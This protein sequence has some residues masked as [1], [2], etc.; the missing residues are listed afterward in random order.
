MTLRRRL[1]MLVV[2]LSA[3]GLV[4]STVVGTALLRRFVLHRVDRQLVSGF[5]NRGGGPGG[6]D[7]GVGGGGGR[8]P[9][10]GPNPNAPTDPDNVCRLGRGFQFSPQ[11]TLTELYRL[12]GSSLCPSQSVNDPG[13]GPVIERSD[14]LHPAGRAFTVSGH[15]SGHDYRVVVNALG[16]DAVVVRAIDLGEANATWRDQAL[17]GG[18]ISLATLV[19]IGGL[20][21]WLVHRGLR[22]LE[23]ISDTADAIAAG[24]RSQRAAVTDPAGEVGRLGLAFNTML[25][26]IDAAFVEQQHSEDKLRQFVADASHE[27]R[28]PLTSIRGYAEL[29]LAGGAATPAKLE[30]SMRN[31]KREAERMTGLVEDLLMLARMDREPQLQL[32]E[33]HLAR[34]VD[35]AVADLR[36]RDANRQVST[37][38]TA[39]V[40]V[41]GDE[42]RLRQVLA[43][44]ISNACTHTPA[45]TP[46]E[47]ALAEVGGRAEIRVIDH[48]HGVPAEMREHIFERFA[49]LDPS[50]TRASGGAGLGLAIVSAIVAAHRGSVRVEPTSGGGATFVVSLP[51]ASASA[52]AAERELAEAPVLPSV[53]GVHALSSARPGRNG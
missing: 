50:R 47:L 5:G 27:L 30:T 21:L 8:G 22:P 17:A 29:Q 25:E 34:L 11:G 15:S 38:A 43:N 41:A 33:V 13:G 51:L 6:P 52:P 12:D 26:S 7:G 10:L 49:R 53:A 4:V 14:L 18:L 9:G 48:G 42:G 1:V 19:A 23:E 45:A 40:R 24:D 37:V 16:N 39:R 32:S 46:I 31:I 2:G 28:T 35:D 3:I 36:A 20:G 44:L